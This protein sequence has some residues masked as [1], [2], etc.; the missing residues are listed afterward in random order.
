MFPRFRQ[1][2]ESVSHRVM[3]GKTHFFCKNAIPR[4][5]PPHKSCA[6]RFFKPNP[7]IFFPFIGVLSREVGFKSI[8]ERQ[9]E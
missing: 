3:T 9:V 5:T 6:R 4:R 1:D 8:F 2:A 7:A